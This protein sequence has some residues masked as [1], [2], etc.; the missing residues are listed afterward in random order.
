MSTVSEEL[1]RAA[2]ERLVVSR[3]LQPHYKC[4]ECGEDCV[5]V[6]D[7]EARAYRESNP[8]TAV[9][10]EAVAH[11]A[12]PPPVPVLPRLPWPAVDPPVSYEHILQFFD[13]AHLPDHLQVVSHMFYQL[14]RRIMDLPRNPER[15]VALRKL[16]EAKDAAVRASVARD[17]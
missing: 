16:L 8:D 10:Q 2:S 12:G 4:D 5:P 14:S 11:A 6:S 1:G 7:E 15:T 17:G 3:G 9:F 13:Y